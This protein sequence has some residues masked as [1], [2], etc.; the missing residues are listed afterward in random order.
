[1]TKQEKNRRAT[2]RRERRMARKT[3]FLMDLTSEEVAWLGGRIWHSGASDHYIASF[4]SVL[5]IAAAELAAKSPTGLITF[6]M[7]RGDGELRILR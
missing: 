2:A 4:M 6:Q 5:P 1:M 3:L 7:R